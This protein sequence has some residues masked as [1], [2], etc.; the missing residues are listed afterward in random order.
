MIN[1]TFV[2]L[3]LLLF[4]PF[5]KGIKGEGSPINGAINRAID[6]AEDENSLID[7]IGD[8]DD[9]G[10]KDPSNANSLKAEAK[11][12]VNG[13]QIASKLEYDSVKVPGDGKEMD[14]SLKRRARMSPSTCID[15]KYILVFVS[16][17][18][19]NRI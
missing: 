1:Q 13:Q 3:K 14:D 17:S 18:G 10:S 2:S 6:G 8:R 11:S 16:C 7:R 15:C 5:D 12:L 4:L 9:G 19:R